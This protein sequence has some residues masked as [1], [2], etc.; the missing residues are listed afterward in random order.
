[1]PQ[2]QVRSTNV[3]LRDLANQPDNGERLAFSEY[4][5]VG[6]AGAAFMLA[7]GRYKFHHY[8]GFEPEL[9]DLV[10]DPGETDNLAESSEHRETVVRFSQRLNDLVDPQAVDRRARADQA[11]LVARFGGRDQALKTGT[12]GATP[13]PATSV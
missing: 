6:S 1:M 11:A 10:T 12:P 8:E 3:S 2:N 7:D 4:H 13:V 5:A 9:F